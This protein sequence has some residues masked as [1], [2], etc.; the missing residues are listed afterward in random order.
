[1]SKLSLERVIK[2]SFNDKALLDMAF[3]HSSHGRNEKDKLRN[4]ERLEFLGDALVDAIVSTVLYE[5]FPNEREGILTKTR[6]QIVCEKSLSAIGKRLK[7]G[8]YLLLGKSEELINGRENN[9]IIADALEALTA[10]IFLDGGYEEAYAFVTREFAST[11]EDAMAGKLFSD[12]KTK[13]QELAS[14]NGLQNKLSYVLTKEE[15]PEHD[16]TFYVSLFL[17]NEEIGEG[18]GK[19]KK[20]AEQK[21]AEE[22]LGRG[23]F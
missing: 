9:G 13:L 23:I 4:N 12:Y 2:Y 21:A 16:K 15:G 6:A 7:L 14:K 11:I 20:D 22:A 5:K 8:Q 10:A 1:M 17:G 3:T 19:R 18:Y